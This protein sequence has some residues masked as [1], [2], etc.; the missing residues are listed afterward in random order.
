MKINEVVPV[1][2]KIHKKNCESYAENILITRREGSATREVHL[3][4]GHSIKCHMSVG[5]PLFE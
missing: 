5:T 3:A 1:I 4:L 2:I